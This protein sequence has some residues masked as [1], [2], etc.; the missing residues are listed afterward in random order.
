VTDPDIWPSCIGEHAASLAKPRNWNAACARS[1]YRLGADIG[2]GGRAVL[3]R[4]NAKGG[5]I[6]GEAIAP[7]ET[8]D[9]EA[10]MSGGNVDGSAALFGIGGTINTEGDL[11]MGGM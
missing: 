10:E 8:H 11:G 3:D 4:I 9:D 6:S 1:Q 7:R 2:S 5:R